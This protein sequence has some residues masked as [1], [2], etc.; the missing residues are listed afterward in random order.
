MHVD[1]VENTLFLCKVSGSEWEAGRDC[2]GVHVAANLEL[3]GTLW[4]R[5]V[6]AL[7]LLC[8]SNLGLDHLLA[9]DGFNF[10]LDEV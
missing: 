4:H 2:A 9:K 8:A 3:I 1:T 10:L 7:L 6:H 5:T